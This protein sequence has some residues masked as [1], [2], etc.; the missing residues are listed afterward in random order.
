MGEKLDQV[1]VTV[2]LSFLFQS[3]SPRV[4]KK[5]RKPSGLG[6]ENACPSSLSPH[7]HKNGSLDSNSRSEDGFVSCFV[8]TKFRLRA[9]ENG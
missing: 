1:K 3:P 5:E 4:F 2:E 8:L 6:D 7:A 9:K